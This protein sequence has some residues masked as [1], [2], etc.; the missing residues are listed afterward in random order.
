M[1]TIK[2]KCEEL[3]DACVIGVLFLKLLFD[4]NVKYIF[5]EF[6]LSV[7]YTMLTIDFLIFTKLINTSS[8][9]CSFIG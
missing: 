1:K 9:F 6:P 8:T 5:M 2:L 3:A 4:V 7:I